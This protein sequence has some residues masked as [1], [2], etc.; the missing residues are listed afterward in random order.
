MQQ[1]KSAL[2]RITA[3]AIAKFLGLPEGAYIDGIF[4]DAEDMVGDSFTL[5]IRGVGRE[6]REGM[7]IRYESL[8]D[9]Q[10]HEPQVL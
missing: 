7:H 8:S 6:Y 9:L 4:Q 5:R 1:R 10:Q 2:V 3:E